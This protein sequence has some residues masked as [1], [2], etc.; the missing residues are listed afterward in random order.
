MTNTA[1]WTKPTPNSDQP[2]RLRMMLFPFVWGAVAI[3]LFLLALLLGWV[4][5]WPWAP[6]WMTP[7]RAIILG[8]PLSAPATWILTRWVQNL[9]RQAGD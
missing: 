1:S 2:W 7:L 4:E 9:L 3:N 8:L 6:N 5:Q